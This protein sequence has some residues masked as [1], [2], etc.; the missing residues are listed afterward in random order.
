MAWAVPEADIAS[1]TQ[2]YTQPSFDIRVVS[3]GKM[4]P[5]LTR[6]SEPLIVVWLPVA[7]VAFE[8][9]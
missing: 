8:L 1:T 6:T 7:T 5:V 4:Y 2:A 3:P 9:S